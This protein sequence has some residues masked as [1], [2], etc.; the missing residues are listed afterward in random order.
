MGRTKRHKGSILFLKFL[1]LAFRIVNIIDIF[2]DL[3]LFQIFLTLIK[4]YLGQKM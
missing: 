4:S 2:N 3:E 1:L